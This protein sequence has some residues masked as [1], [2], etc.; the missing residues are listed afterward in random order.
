MELLLNLDAS[1]LLWIQEHL[2]TPGMTVFF[3]QITR[4]GNAGIFCILLSLS[5]ILFTKTRKT[6]GMAIIS[7]VI[8]FVINN[9]FLKNVVARTRPYEV[10]EGLTRLIEK[11]PDYSFPSGHTA[12]S[13]VVA[14]I[15][16]L[17]LP[18]KYGIPLL[19]LAVLISFSRL[20][21][22]V[23]YPSDVLVGAVS[24][25]LIALAV[26]RVF[27]HRQESEE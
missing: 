20:Y 2:R 3:R 16:Y 25:I 8:S 14:M 4:L 6:G 7:L 1:I 13:F 19:V 5:L 27:F 18:K 21:L 15:L 10:V 24:G 26:H 9:L 22:G 23:H 17:E 11:Q 12:S